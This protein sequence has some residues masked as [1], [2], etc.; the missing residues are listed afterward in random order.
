MEEQGISLEEIDFEG[1]DL[2]RRVTNSGTDEAL[3]QEFM[4][5]CIKDPTGTL[6]GK[7]ILFA[8]SHRHAMN[9]YQAFERLYPE[10][11]GRLVEVIDSHMEGADRM[12]KR[13]KHENYPR[14]AISV[15]M[16]DTGVD[17]REVVNLVFAKPIY[18]RVKFWQ[19][20]GRGTRLLDPNNM[21]PWC[22]Q[23]DHFLIIDHWDNFSYFDMHPEGHTPEPSEA[24]PVRRFRTQVDL[25]EALHGKGESRN[26]VAI[27]E[28]LCDTI[29]SLPAGFVEVQAARADIERALEQPFWVSPGATE[30]THLRI[31]IAPLCRFLLDVDEA[32]VSFAYK[33]ERIALGL[34]LEDE[35]EIGRQKERIRADLRLLPTNLRDVKAHERELMEA[36]AE[37][38]WSGLSYGSIIRLRD[39]FAPLMRYRRTQQRSLIEL[40]VEDTVIDRRWIIF[41]PAGEG[42]YVENYREQVE[43][44]IRELADSDPSRVSHSNSSKVFRSIKSTGVAV[45]P[46]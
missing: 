41:G 8:I 3:V 6:P 29:R 11:K 39:T 24:L 31:K 37:P 28:E 13:F 46:N 43:A 19:M 27:G 5:V 15:D 36:I 44:R 38:F 42:T 17:I 10:Y 45:S 21:K 26:A 23:K 1:T 16:L 40:N 9:L 18:S 12:L 34:L 32:G 14:V 30:Y 7:S 22:R 2:E 35:G 33:A 20:I 4:D 25:L